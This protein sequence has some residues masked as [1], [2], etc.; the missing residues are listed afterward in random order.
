MFSGR[1]PRSLDPNRLTVAL[2]ARRRSGAPILDLTASNP[3]GAGIPRPRDL[4]APLADPR[5]LV[6]EP[7]PR[8]LLPARE[9]VAA[10]HARR[11]VRVS[12]D[13]ILLTASTSEAYAF[14][15]KL[16]CDAGD[17][18]LIPRPGYPLFE[19]L[20]RLESVQ[21]RPYSL[22]Y[23]GEWHLAISAVEA[24]L[25]PRTR[26][27][28]VVSPNNPTGSFLK[29]D[30]A[31]ALQDLCARKGIALVADE[32]FADYS[33][34]PDPRRASSLAGDGP[35]LAFALGGLSKSCGLP[36]LKLGWVAVSG[37][38]ALREQAMA[39]L[40]LVADTFLSVGTPVQHA[41]PWLL[42]RLAELQAPI[43]ARVR[44]NLEGLQERLGH[45]A[46]ATLLRPEGGWAAVLRVPATV[47]E[48]DLV[49]RLLESRGVLCHPGYFFDFPGEAFLVVSLL[50][51]PAVFRAGV[52]AILDQASVL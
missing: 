39:R 2:E 25:T 52:A 16:L 18:V 33:F 43:A 17:D 6:Y 9:A 50:P 7:S 29:R 1:T 26:A 44:E 12:A 38:A 42:G 8:G 27:I 10:D 51:P 28:V 48:E 47:P 37:P 11:G 5:S 15:F 22:A 20:S 45:D 3:T 13:R 32:V 35:A 21:V 34:G 49:L 14:L 40:E 30:E 41:A 4:L 31:E 24:A 19:L 46:K 23:D 36:Q